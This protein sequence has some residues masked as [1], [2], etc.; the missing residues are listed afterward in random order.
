[1]KDQFPFPPKAK[2]PII[3]I[4]EPPESRATW[5]FRT[6]FILAIAGTMI[7]G[8][9]G[10]GVYWF[11]SKDLPPIL[12]VA[13]Y[14]PQTVTRVIGNNGASIAALATAPTPNASGK[15]STAQLPPG[16]GTPGVPGVDD[17]LL[18]EFYKQRRYIVP[19]DR[20]PDV[21]IKAFI[22]SEDDQFFQ[23]PGVNIASIIRAAIANFKAGHKVQGGSTITQQ[24]AKMLLL[25]PAQDYTRKIK[26]AILASRFEK[27]MSKQDILY[28]Y[29][30]EMYLGHGAYGVQAAS[31]TYF[32]KDISQVTLP[33]AAILAGLPQAPSKYSPVLAPQ[34]AKERQIY[35]LR[36]MMEIG[37]ITPAQMDE[38]KKAPVR[39]Y[40][41]E[42]LNLK[43]AGHLV[44]HIRRVVQEK[45]GEKAVY[46][47]GMTIQ[48][49]ASRA[50]SIAAAKSLR[51]GLR[52]VDKGLGYR[53]PLK[54]LKPDQQEAFLRETKLKLIGKK[55]GYVVLLADGKVDALEAMREAGITTEQQLLDIGEIYEGLV[56]SVDDKKKTVDVAIGP[57]ATTL[58]FERMK[59]AKP[60][61]EAT[62]GK[63]PEPALPSRVLAKGD[64]ILA[65]YL[66]TPEKATG[67]HVALEQ[68]PQVEGALLSID[69]KTGY[70]MA[71]E[72]GFGYSQSQFNRAIQA[73][74]QPG[75]AFKPFIYAAGLEKGYTPA[76]II[77]DAPIVYEDSETGKWKPT[78]FEEKFYGDTTFRQA[79]IKSRNVPTIKIVQT[80]QVSKMIEYA[81][82]LG[83]SGH[84]N[85]DLSISLGSGSTSLLDLT[86]AYALFPRLGRKVDGIFYTKILDRDARVLEEVVP[87]P[88]PAEVKIPPLPPAPEATAAAVADGSSPSVV[89]SPAPS[90]PIAPQATAETFKPIPLPSYP[91]AD[92]PDQVLDPRVAYVMTHLMKEVV[93][94][95]T[96][97]EARSLGRAAAGKTGTTNEYNDAWFM[98]FTPHVV[99]G[100]WVGFDNQKQM[101]STGTGAK[102]ALPIWLGYMTEAVKAYPEEDFTAPPGVTFASIDPTT[103]RL[104]P[105]NSSRSI[106]EAFIDGTQ[107]MTESTDPLANRQETQTD[108]FKEDLE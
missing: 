16:M 25:T 43:Y 68:E 87:K 18:G 49:P 64:V 35:V 76:T 90:A 105:S 34:K 40:D 91:P 96:G 78:N 4:Q 103:G 88:L 73:Q 45:Y 13:D 83:M 106:K 107:P 89:A 14:K 94:Y 27:N 1:M 72:G 74:R 62:P 58:A 101:G 85:Q 81:R 97:Y 57:V 33:E 7:A 70:V 26:E 75:S 11:F 80:V 108:F 23:H 15:P 22:A 39:I 99:T 61:R 79:L 20:I 42:N 100:V 59:W 44:E 5:V 28:L 29:L 77:V 52:A 60:Y 47:S 50:L 71:M 8:V 9:V 30:N 2:P 95:G 6:L 12:N 67:L 53:G 86:R 54:R 24:V 38:A 102:A 84:F 48:I 10:G 55:I 46:E 56:T 41:D 31:K 36:R 104:S 37:A 69:I 21:V 63:G 3:P 93:N 98:G 82:R 17:E 19:Y 32:R 66:G 51:D 92:D 65:K